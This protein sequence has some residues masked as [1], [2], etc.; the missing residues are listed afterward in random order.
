MSIFGKKKEQPGS[1]DATGEIG[2][3]AGNPTDT[4]VEIVKQLRQQGMTNNQII[5][6]LQ[7]QGY[8]STQIFDAL[9][10]A[11]PTNQPADQIPNQG[12]PGEEQPQGPPPG[13]PIQE[14]PAMDMSQPMPPQPMEA[15][16]RIEEMAEDIIY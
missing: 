7:Q 5:Q 6:D 16:E 15:K 12:M 10:F 11:E 8:N 1:F 13:V 3:P 4:P 9:N 2:A 14:M